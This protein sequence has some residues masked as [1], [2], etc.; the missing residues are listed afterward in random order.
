MLRLP[1]RSDPVTEVVAKKITRWPNP[2]CAIQSRYA[3]L[4]RR[5]LKFF[6]ATSDQ[7][8][9]H[10]N[11]IPLELNYVAVS[12]ERALGSPISKMSM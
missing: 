1:D 2:A 7:P 5:R 12:P 10:W 4:R 9:F 11:S 6:T 3:A 8:K